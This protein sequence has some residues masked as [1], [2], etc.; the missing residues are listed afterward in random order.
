MVNFHSP[1]FPSVGGKNG[2]RDVAGLKCSGRA[3]N[4]QKHNAEFADMVLDPGRIDQGRSRLGWVY[5]EDRQY[6]QKD[7]FFS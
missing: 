4:V 5:D 3:P 7:D 6:E 2:A 1:F